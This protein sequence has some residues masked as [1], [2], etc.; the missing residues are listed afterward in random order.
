[1]LK[2]EILQYLKV[3]ER[4]LRNLIN[5]GYITVDKSNKAKH[6][7]TIVDESFL[8]DF[9]ETQYLAR[10]KEQSNQKRSQSMTKYIQQHPEHRELISRRTSEE[11]QK[12]PEVLSK[13]SVENWQKDSF[14]AIQKESRE[15]YW[16]NDDN[17]AAHGQIIKTKVWGNHRDTMLL[18]M[19]KRWSKEE[20]HIK[21]RKSLK[22]T[23]ASAQVRQNVSIGVKASYE[24]D[25]KAIYEKRMITRRKNKTVKTS[26]LQ[27]FYTDWFNRK[28]LT[29]QTE[30]PY[31][32]EPTLHCD[33]LLDEL[34]LYIEGHF[35]WTHDNRP[36]DET[37]EYCLK[38]LEY[39]KQRAATSKYYANKIYTWTNSDVR[40]AKSAAKDNLNWIALY[41]V[42]EFEQFFSKIQYNQVILRPWDNYKKIILSTS[43]KTK[44]MAR[45]CD[46]REVS[47]KDSKQFLSS[48][49]YQGPTKTS[50]VS[51][52]LYYNDE[53][54]QLM[55]F[56]KPRY[57]RNYE[58][59]LLRLCSKFGYSITGGSTK[60][61]SHF[62]TAYKPKSIISYCDKDKFSGTVYETLGFSKLSEQCSKHWYNYWED[63]HITDNLL[64][65]RG[66]DALLKTSYGKGTSNDDIMRAH[67]YIEITD[68]GQTTYI[69][70]L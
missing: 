46:I 35:T 28:G 65:Q 66:A 21:I 1:M 52:G 32:S 19:E 36:F 47:L 16:S 4:T 43:D 10:K 45:K 26:K 18:G 33:W 29:V 38:T 7:Y 41:S 64:R 9:D 15:Q 2:S 57:N 61:L 8:A 6:Q 42:K 17:R 58:Y 53:L 13:R 34:D 27:E 51:L 54:V 37:D 39:C 63:R 30:V 44:L 25:G 60:L 69:K 5:D 49:H 56:G 40:R 12:I 67:N 48:Y 31:P 68:S 59:E 24:R 50:L 22:A 70:L 55:T 20:E 3:K 23:Y 62:E 11:L 14:R